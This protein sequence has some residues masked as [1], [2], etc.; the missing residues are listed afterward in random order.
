MDIQSL[1]DN[2]IFLNLLSLTIIYWASLVYPNIKIFSTLSSYG[3]LLAN[4]SLFTLLALRW[5]NFGYFPFRVS[6]NAGREEA[7]DET[8][9]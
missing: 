6:R 3:N 4:L 7:R 5:L 2:I 1:L 9:D 8:I